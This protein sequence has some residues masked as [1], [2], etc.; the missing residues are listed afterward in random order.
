MRIP[1]VSAALLLAAL[2]VSC[3]SAPPEPEKKAAAAPAPPKVA[4]HTSV[5]LSE[6]RVSVSVVPDHLLGNKALPGGSLGEYEAKGRKYQLFIVEAPSTQQAAFL[7]LDVKGTLADADYIAYM[8]GY[9]GTDQGKPMYVFA[10][11]QYLAGVVGLSK[12]AADPIARQLAAQL[13]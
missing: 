6:N 8:G 2:L 1:A 7:L 9:F 4:D 12:D 3:G 11:Q 5:L 10:K 13:H